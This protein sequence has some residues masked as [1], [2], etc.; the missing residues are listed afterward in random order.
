[1][2][3]DVKALA[4]DADRGVLWVGTANGISRVVAG[5]PGDPAITA[6]TYV[7]PNPSRAAGTLKLGGLQN[8]L[9]GEIRDVAGNVLHRFHCDPAAN[10]IW[11]LTTEK[12]DPAP[13]GVYLVV[14]HD[15]SGGEKTLRA[16]VVR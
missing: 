11:D 14:L 1:V 4:W 5:V 16:A 7:Y 3:D 8:A 15:R 9:D 12:G 2:D 10:E 6:D 13:S